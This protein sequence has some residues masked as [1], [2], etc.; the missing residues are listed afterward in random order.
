MTIDNSYLSL[1][2]RQ[3]KNLGE[4][5][6]GVDEG[7]Q[8]VYDTHPSISDSFATVHFSNIEDRLIEF[9]DSAESLVGCVAWLTSE[10]VLQAMCERKSVHLIVQKE[11]WLRPDTRG[12]WGGRRRDLYEALPSLDAYRFE[13]PEPVG[14][15]SYLGSPGPVD[16]VRCLG[17]HNSTRIPATPH[18]HHKFLVAGSWESEKIDKTRRSTKFHP[19]RVWTGS[20]NMTH[21][22]TRSL[23]NVVVLDSSVL[24]D[25]YCREFLMLMAASEPLDWE[26][27]W[28]WPQYRIG[29]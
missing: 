24:A 15:L 13:W 16:A 5:R 29:T 12:S 9:M 26:S 11:D 27:A 6:G 17:N 2:E 28:A 21:S 1:P 23:E 8:Y 19:E 25:E 7:G 22:A 4:L 14:S 3:T 18:M 20:Y 10:R